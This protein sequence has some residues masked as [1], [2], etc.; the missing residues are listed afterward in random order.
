MVR[1]FELDIPEETGIYQSFVVGHNTMV[2]I[3]HLLADGSAVEHR[4]CIISRPRP[5]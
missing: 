3:L 2:E 1:T 4:I 5:V